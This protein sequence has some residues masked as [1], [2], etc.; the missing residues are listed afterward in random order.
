MHYLLVCWYVVLIYYDLCRLM[1]FVDVGCLTRCLCYVEVLLLLGMF[2]YWMLCCDIIVLR[3]VVSVYIFAESLFG[4]M[5][6]IV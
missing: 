1:C 3:I 4:C 6:Y 5:V 2:C